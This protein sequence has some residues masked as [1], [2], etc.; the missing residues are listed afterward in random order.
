M[1]KIIEAIG[2]IIVGI[3]FFLSAITQMILGPVLYACGFVVVFSGMLWGIGAN[4]FE[5][6]FF[7]SL[8]F[9]IIGGVIYFICDWFVRD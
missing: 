2:G 7:Y 5:T 6:I 1:K 8:G 9:L 4:S 3:L